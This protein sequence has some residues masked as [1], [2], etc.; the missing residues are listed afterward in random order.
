MHARL[1]AAAIS[2]IVFTVS[3]HTW[4]TPDKCF[5]GKRVHDQ[6][7]PQAGLRGPAELGSEELRLPFA[8]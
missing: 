6:G 4:V 8:G 1:M 7:V 5:P 2:L 3:C